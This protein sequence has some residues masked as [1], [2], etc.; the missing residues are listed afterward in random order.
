MFIFFVFF[1]FVVVNG[2]ETENGLINS[3]NLQELYFSSDYFYDTINLFGYKKDS[4]FYLQRKNDATRRNIYCSQKLSQL[5]EQVINVEYPNDVFRFTWFQSFARKHNPL[6]LRM[7][8]MYD[9]TIIVVKYVQNKKNVKELISDSIFISNNCWDLFCATVDSLYFFDMQPIEKSDILVMDGS[10]WIL[11]GKINNE[12]H[13]VYREEG[14]NKD[15]GLIC[16]KLVNYYNNG[17]IKFKL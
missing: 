3:N 1:F 8:K 5:K 6:T 11:E 2:Q 16:M 4:M 15:I 14:E 7:E 9:S 13:M 10:T 12:Y 17:K